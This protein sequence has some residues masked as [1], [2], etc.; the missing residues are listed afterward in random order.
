MNAELTKSLEKYLCA[1]SELIVQ[2]DS[3][4]VRDV[5][6]YLSVGG[7]STADAIR[8]LKTKGYIN[9]EP[10]QNI[11]LTQKGIEKINLKKSRTKT[12][13]QFFNSVLNIENDLS[14]SAAENMEFT[15][16]EVVLE[17]FVNFLNFMEKC[18]CK[19]PK[20]ITSCKDTLLYGILPPK[21]K[22]CITGKQKLCCCGGCTN[23]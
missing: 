11:T 21:C 4:K 10:Y 19:N 16:S 18:S 20:W 3:V 2:N 6:D 5:A 12:I 22:D 8:A 17:K 15:M 14:Q 7:P 9:Y 1:I 13:S 23:E